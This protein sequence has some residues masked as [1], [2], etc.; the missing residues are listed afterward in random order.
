MKYLNLNW[1]HLCTSSYYSF[2]SVLHLLQRL[3]ISPQTL[4]DDLSTVR[5]ADLSS[6]LQQLVHMG[7]LVATWVS[8]FMTTH[9]LHLLHQFQEGEKF[10]V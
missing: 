5:V 10:T 7:G 1:L 2:A 6:F 3:M 9:G 8:N 4:S